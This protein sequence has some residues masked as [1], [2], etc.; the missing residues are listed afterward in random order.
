MKR[1]LM[2]QSARLFSSI[3]LSPVFAPRQLMLSTSS[4][5]NTND[6]VVEETKSPSRRRRRGS[7]LLADE[8][9]P[10]YK[11]FV[12]R[13]TV[14]SLYRNYLKAI[15]SM[16]HNQKDLKDQVQREFRANKNDL[17]PL[18]IQRALAEGKRRYE[19]LQDFT[20]NNKKY[21]GDSWLSTKDA[22][23]PRGRVG[24]GWPWL[25]SD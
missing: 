4:S 10:S 20:G 21:D 1:S 16:P 9:I 5:I 13:F 17:N 24:Q 7:R 8:N 15:R 2:M 22:E 23:D 19:E 18:N 11:E 14:L 12:H 6:V 25:R 3:R